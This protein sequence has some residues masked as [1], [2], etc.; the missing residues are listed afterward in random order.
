MPMLD[1]PRGR[2]NSEIPPAT[3]ASHA[4][5]SLAAALK[6]SSR[7]WLPAAAE[8]R[9]RRRRLEWRPL[10]LVPALPP[11][12][13]VATLL[14]PPPRP[15]VLFTADRGVV[16]PE[17][18]LVDNGNDGDAG[19]GTATIG[20]PVVVVVTTAVLLIVIAAL[21]LAL[22][23][24]G[25]GGGG[26]GR[27]HAPPTADEVLAAA[28]C[29]G[30]VGVIPPALTRVVPKED[31]GRLMASREEVGG[32]GGVVAVAV[33]DTVAVAVAACFVKSL[34]VA[35]STDEAETVESGSR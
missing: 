8:A 33:S 28:R 25:G 13:G 15:T 19:N 20:V 29:F 2:L 14:P 3:T 9:R 24:E 5:A 16:I 11:V 7:C 1:T 17:R 26:G 22:V 18:A 4:D 21:V 35:T 27:E 31:L 10:A 32:G 34:V 23:G 30:V 6:D 12:D